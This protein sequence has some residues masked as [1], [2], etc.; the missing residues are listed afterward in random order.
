MKRLFTLLLAVGLLSPAIANAQAKPYFG[1]SIGASFYNTSV[2]DVTGDDFKL[3]GEDFAWKIFGGI[4]T[5]KFLSVEGGYVH[6]GEVQNTVSLIDLSTKTT[7]WDLFAV[8]NLTAGPIDVFGKAGIL[9]WR[10]DAKIDEDPFDVTGTD[11][12]WGLG[13][14][15]RF[16]GVGIRAEFERFELPDSDN[17]MMLSAGVT[18]GM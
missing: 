1:G 13:A 9:W 11:F 4:R 12:A 2:E 16:G 14:A 5:M 6:L 18:F 15:M 7:G 8:G 17:I 10:S 3:E